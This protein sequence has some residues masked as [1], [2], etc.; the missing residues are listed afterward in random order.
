MKAFLKKEWMEL[1]RT[2]RLL[3]L[4]LLFALFGIM[5]PAVAKLTPWLMET[6]SDS[7]ADTGIVMK[8]VTVTAMT[9][10]MQFYKNIPVGLLIFVV[11]N[12]NSFSA[13]YQKGTLI[14]VVTKGLSRRKIVLAK[15]ILIFLS[16]TALYWLCFGITYA[17]NAYFW[18]NDVAS[19]LLF[20]ASLT[21]LF[22]MG[23]AAL[24]IFFSTIGQSATQA[25]L[26]T[27]GVVMG[28][29]ILRIFPRLDTFLPI[30]LM[31]GTSL[32]HGASSPE[33]YWVSI[34]ATGILILF[35]MICAVVCFERKRL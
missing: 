27:G 28:A 21:W 33:D 15:T 2:G 22:G 12:S 9:S 19:H 18:D 5:N 16:W 6:I 10:W 8:D 1:Y 30:R 24:F 3:L 13:E 17:Y 23:V 25:L 34:A 7:F 35:C 11:L 32:L 29:Y 26:S 31:D 4:L 20:A 14:P